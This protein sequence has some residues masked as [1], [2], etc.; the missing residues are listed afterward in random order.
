MTD[1]QHNLF[2]AIFKIVSAFA[3]IYTF[4]VGLKQFEVQTEIDK[5]KVFYEK[6]MEYINDLVS[7]TSE[8]SLRT[9]KRNQRDSLNKKFSSL[10]NGKL[11]FYVSDPDLINTVTEFRH[12]SVT[13][14]I[15]TQLTY[16]K[17]DKFG[18]AKEL[19]I[20]IGNYAK[21]FIDSLYNV[22]L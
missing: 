19:S 14:S 5:T 9:L 16:L 12:A 8:L 10:Y 11:Q 7:V 22:Q 20:N 15:D 18:V 4:Y 13:L 21:T 1:N 6:Q 2:D 17:R 3:V